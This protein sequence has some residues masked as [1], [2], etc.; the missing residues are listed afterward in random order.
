M[1]SLFLS[2]HQMASGDIS[3]ERRT[4]VSVIVTITEPRLALDALVTAVRRP[5][6]RPP[7]QRWPAPPTSPTLRRPLR[8][9]RTPCTAAAS[10]GPNATPTDTS[11]H[12]SSSTASGT[13]IAVAPH[14]RSRSGTPGHDY[15][16]C[17]EAR[18]SG[19]AACA[20]NGCTWKTTRPSDHP[21]RPGTPTSPPKITHSRPRPSTPLLTAAMRVTQSLPCLHQPRLRCGRARTV[22][23]RSHVARS[24]QPISRAVR[25]ISDRRRGGTRRDV[26]TRSGGSA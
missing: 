21:C 25:V 26:G 2:S 3:A 18:T 5:L 8:R 11:P 1:E 23:Q 24:G 13:P 4:H 22:R 12:P 6:P 7:P 20:K 10:S 14:H 15:L 16:P 17:R 19:D 9:H